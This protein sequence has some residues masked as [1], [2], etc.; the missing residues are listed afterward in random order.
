MARMAQVYMNEHNFENAFILYIKFSTLFLEKVIAHPE[1]KSFDPAAKKQ[2]REKL[3]EIFPIAEKLKLK[4]KE[5]FQ[6][7]FV[8]VEKDRRLQRER[9]AAE[10]KEKV[11]VFVM[12]LRILYLLS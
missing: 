6:N 12:K 9:E 3:K 8:Q 1:Y 7:D 4:L 2:N 5:K 10:R 11:N